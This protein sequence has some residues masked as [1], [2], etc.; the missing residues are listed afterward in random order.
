MLVK[1][2][3]TLIAPRWLVSHGYSRRALMDVHDRRRCAAPS[4]ASESIEKKL[5]TAAHARMALIAGTSSD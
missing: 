1:A 4:L 3:D 2:S 5:Y